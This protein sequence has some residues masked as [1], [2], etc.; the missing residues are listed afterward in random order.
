VWRRTAQAVMKLL[1]KFHVD[2]TEE[3]AVHYFQA[4]WPLFFHDPSDSPRQTLR[5]IRT[6]CLR[7]ID[8][9]AAMIA[10]RIGIV[11]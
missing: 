8:Y 10:I 2:L 6:V 5:P 7:S 3:E 1:E 4:S 9:S 11:R